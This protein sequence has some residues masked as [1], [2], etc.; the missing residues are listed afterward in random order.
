LAEDTSIL[1][2]SIHTIKENSEKL[3]ASKET[4]QEVNAHKTKYMFMYEDQ[5]AR[6]DHKMKIDNHSFERVE[7]LKFWEEP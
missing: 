1:G 7:Q 5:T 2:R 3:F 6:Q 4:R